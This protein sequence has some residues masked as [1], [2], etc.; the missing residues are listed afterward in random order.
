MRGDAVLNGLSALA[1]LAVERQ[2]G[3]GEDGRKEVYDFFT[4]NLHLVLEVAD[5]AVRAIEGDDAFLGVHDVEEHTWHRIRH[6]ADDLRVLSCS[7]QEV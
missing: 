2:V 4:D 5:F 6:L 1:R 3:L 7:L